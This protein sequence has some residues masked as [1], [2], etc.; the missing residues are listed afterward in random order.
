MPTATNRRE[1]PRCHICQAELPWHRSLVVIA[2]RIFC[3]THARQYHARQRLG[4][5]AEELET[6]WSDTLDSWRARP[7]VLDQECGPRWFPFNYLFF[8]QRIEGWV[9]FRR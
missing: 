9:L 3:A 7:R 5:R 8:D 4:V 2:H 1:R 6:R